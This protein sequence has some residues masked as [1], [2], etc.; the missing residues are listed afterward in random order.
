MPNDYYKSP[1]F[2]TLVAFIIWGCGYI[3]ADDA[4]IEKQ[5]RIACQWKK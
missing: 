2:L 1:W 3:M 5:Q 4:R